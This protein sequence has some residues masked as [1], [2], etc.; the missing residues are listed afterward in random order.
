MAE[1]EREQPS[2]DPKHR[3]AGAVILV[4]LAVIFVPMILD[5]R[6]PAG[7]A[8]AVVEI[9]DRDAAATAM[10]KVVVSRLDAPAARATAVQV[11]SAPPAAGKA[12]ATEPAPSANPIAPQA[13]SAAGQAAEESPPA[14][15]GTPSTPAEA[16]PRSAPKGGWVV[17]VGTFANFDNAVRL[18]ERLRK[19][20]HEVSTENITLGDSKAVR[21]RVGPFADRHTALEVQAR[22]KKEIGVQGAV[23]AER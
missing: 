2:F 22:I 12:P 16:A 4:S 14:R 7:K 18:R 9:P 13:P 23:L 5:E 11:P 6:E 20:G 21:L 17:Q 15:T 3:I 10:T 1:K 8:D 19:H